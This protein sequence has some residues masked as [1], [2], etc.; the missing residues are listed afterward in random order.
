M[1][2]KG[3]QL[4][5][6]V[7]TTKLPR[8]IE[9]LKKI[10]SY[11]YEQGLFNTIKRYIYLINRLFQ[12]KYKGYRKCNTEYHNFK[13]TLDTL[14]AV[15]RLIDGYNLSQDKI[16]ADMSLNILAAA[17][18]HDTGYIQQEWDIYGTGAKYTDEHVERS[19]IF[20]QENAQVFK[21]KVQDI[22]IINRLINCSGFNAD[23]SEVAFSSNQEKIAGAILGTGDLLGQMSDRLYL[24]KLLFLYY[25]FREA[26]IPGYNTEYDIIRKTVDFYELTKERFKTNFCNVYKYARIHFRERC[27]HDE[28]I[29]M[30]AIER[31][32][33]YIKKIIEDNSTNFRHK[34]NRVSF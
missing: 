12:G 21:I 8:I 4:S 27:G 6:I 25:E 23:L 11:N 18:L 34:L 15:I 2:I 7:N 17:L 24:E 22:S 29:Y 19:K 1:V 16:E 28:N 32:I 13:H 3:I 5:R 26:G 9:E 31:N 33:N 14:L 30:V 10:F 20:V